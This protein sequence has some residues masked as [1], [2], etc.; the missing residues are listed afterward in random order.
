MKDKTRYKDTKMTEFSVGDRVTKISDSHYPNL[1]FS[2]KPIIPIGSK[3]TVM[4]LRKPYDYTPN[5]NV[6][7]VIKFDDYNFNDEL[8]DQYKGSSLQK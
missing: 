1:N 7:Y 6:L 4:R 3:G 2:G 5:F 8:I